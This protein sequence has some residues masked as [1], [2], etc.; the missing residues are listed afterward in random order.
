MAKRKPERQVIA[1]DRLP[2]ELYKLL[3]YANLA[4]SG[5]EAKLLISEGLVRLNGDVETRKSKKIAAG[6]VVGL[7][8]HELEVV[9]EVSA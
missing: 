4:Q 8:G 7:E 6:D 2:I 1:L 9:Q 5:G 3:K